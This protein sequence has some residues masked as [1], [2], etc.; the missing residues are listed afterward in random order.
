MRQRYRDLPEKSRK[1]V[2]TMN[3]RP[4]SLSHSR[5]VHTQ[6]KILHALN[7]GPL[8]FNELIKKTGT[9]RQTL[10]RHLPILLNSGLIRTLKQDE[11]RLTQ[12]LFA[13]ASYTD[14]EFDVENAFKELQARGYARISLLLLESVTGRPE[15][16]EFTEIAFKMAKKYDLPIGEDDKRDV[17]QIG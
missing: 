1:T 6:A 9:V 14:L 3:V 17:S 8:T 12:Q 5:E 13:L 15:T 2:T 4:L 7:S 10:Y 16:K 11:P